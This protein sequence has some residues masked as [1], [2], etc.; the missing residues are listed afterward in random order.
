M[1][2]PP[3]CTTLEERVAMGTRCRDCDDVPKVLDAGTV[4]ADAE[5][6]QVQIMHNG[7]RVLAGG[8]Y[9][10][11]MTDLIRLL[12]GHHESQEER[13]FHEVMKHLAPDATM[14][15]LGGFWS[16]YS[17]WFKKNY[18][19]RRSI[20]I[21]PEPSHLAVGQE[22]AAING[23]DIAFLQGFA[24]PAFVPAQEFVAEV[25]G[26][27][28]IP[29]YSV[30][31]LM[32]HGGFKRINLLHLDIQGAE[33]AVLDSC[34]DL[35]LA[36]QVD[37]VF[38]STHAHQISGDPLT[39]QRCLDILRGCGAVIEADIDVHESFSGDGLIVARF[40]SAPQG[41]TTVPLTCNRHS[42]SLFRNLA[43]D[44]AEA[45]ERIAELERQLEATP[46]AKQQG[47]KAASG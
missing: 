28:T 32:Q 4:I 33:T 20:V 34:R 11:W 15:E 43:Y 18:P 29:G 9:G 27:I 16:Y 39:H 37:W 8:Y 7:L 22:N 47:D 40:C 26:T 38:A 3:D 25:A 13:V 31:H 10:G 14:I 6:R 23:V 12:R 45:R 30:H 19:D 1:I 36:G 5:G 46:D 42:Q 35:F 21:E 41:W 24:A 2:F 17:I 44:L